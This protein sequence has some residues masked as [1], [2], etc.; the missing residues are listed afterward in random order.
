[1]RFVD[2]QPLGCERMKFGPDNQLYM[3]SLTTGLT[4]L[5]FIGPAPLAIERVAIRKAGK[6]FELELTR[7]LAA[8]TTLNPADFHV[9][10]YHYDYT[11][12]YGSPEADAVAV[13]VASAGLSAD[14]KKIT[15]SFP[16]ES[17][18]IG[19]IYEINAGQLRDEEGNALVHN[20]AWYTVHQ[21]PK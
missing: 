9:R 4:R 21:I 1:M 7:P 3:A 14:R 18:P 16:V 8:D 13:N 15:L 10:R 19:M 6:G 12:N 2:G 17:Y 20:Q 11:G 5:K